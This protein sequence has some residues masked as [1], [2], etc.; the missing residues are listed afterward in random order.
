LILDHRYIVTRGVERGGVGS[1]V[2]IFCSGGASRG[3]NC[4]E[5]WVFK[6]IKKCF[7]SIN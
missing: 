1:I 6:K 4:E 7:D 3:D 2:E 5:G